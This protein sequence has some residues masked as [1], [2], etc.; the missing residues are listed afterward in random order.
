MYSLPPGADATIALRRPSVGHGD[1][2]QVLGPRGSV[3]SMIEVPF[4][5]FCRVS[6]LYDES[7]GVPGGRPPSPGPLSA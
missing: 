4:S 2:E 6:G 3:T 1:V 5:S 7:G